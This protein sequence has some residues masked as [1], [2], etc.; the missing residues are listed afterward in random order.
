MIHR[1]VKIYVY[2]YTDLSIYIYIYIHIYIEFRFPPGKTK[3]KEVGMIFAS[4]N[5]SQQYLLLCRSDFGHSHYQPGLVGDMPYHIV[6][7]TS[8]SPQN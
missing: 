6:Q 3:A 4:K 7:G 8:F 1:D 5:H 2:I